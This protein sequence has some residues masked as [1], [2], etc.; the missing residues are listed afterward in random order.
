MCTR[1]RWEEL[2]SALDRE[3]CDQK[4]SQLVLHQLSD[5]YQSLTPR[6]QKVVDRVLAEWASS[7]DEAKRFD[8]IAL[9]R[10][11]EI[12]SAI[13]ALREVAH[14]LLRSKEPGAPFEIAKI[15]RVIGKLVLKLKSQ[16]L[17]P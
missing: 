12:A 9:I 13:P 3:A 1:G 8:A 15:E 2:R 16:S 11:H 10:E 17:P 7:S 4:N 6:D 14:A 5:E